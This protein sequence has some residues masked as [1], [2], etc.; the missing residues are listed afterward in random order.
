[1]VL[2]TST[3]RYT[4]TI[5]IAIACKVTAPVLV[6]AITVAIA[7]PRRFA[8][9]AITRA[10][11]NGTFRASFNILTVAIVIAIASQVTAILLVFTI[12]VAIT[13]P[14]GSTAVFICAVLDFIF[15]TL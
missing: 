2:A 10:I 5:V 1:L 15:T 6:S 3:V 14:R 9:V 4:V 12:T 13:N 8:A 7:Q 11:T